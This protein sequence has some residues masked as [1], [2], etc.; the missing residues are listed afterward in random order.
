MI[1]QEKI[2]KA[3][4][5]IVYFNTEIF[6][7]SFTEPIV[8]APHTNRW[9]YDMANN[10]HTAILS[11]RKH[12]KSISVYSYLMW[13]LLRNVDEHRE[14]FYF[15][16]NQDIAS[17]H[18][19]NIKKLIQTNPYF[20]QVTNHTPA[21][22]ILE[23]SWDGKHMFTVKPQGMTSFKRG[24]HPHEV[25]CDDI[26]ADPTNELNLSIIEKINNI[27]FKEVMSL[28]KEGG[29]L[30]LVG[31]AQT[32]SDLFF[33]IKQKS[34]K[35]KWGMYKAVKNWEKKQ[36]LWKELFSFERLMEIR[37][38]EIGEKAFNQEYMCSPVYS[39]KAYF[40]KEQIEIVT[41]PGLGNLESLR[42][43][44]RVLL[45][46]DIGK[47]RHPS[48]I[49]VFE[50]QGDK[51][52]QRLSQWLDGWDYSRQLSLIKS[53]VED[54]S[55]DEGYFDATR[56]EFDTMT[57]QGEM[58]DALKP[59]IFKKKNK[60]AMASLFEKIVNRKNIELIDDHRQTDQILSVNND[61]DAIETNQGHGDSFWSIAMAL[62][63]GEE[64]KVII[65]W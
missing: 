5:D 44:N 55:V 16:Y 60:G 59:L 40:K 6:P 31:T 18:T 36:V 37:D 1:E 4:H 57:E 52:I 24:L 11:A 64:K 46:W 47:K 65:D 15:S 19:S 63:A 54:F 29:H 26:L 27:F 45:G 14:I 3:V 8:K 50:Q 23:Y 35:F 38:E 10:T 43:D 28:P 39:E 56:G 49:V 20:E 30:K 2:A 32:Q 41:N 34:T 7:L 21:A 9:V 62:Y 48:H 58:P 22:G 51:Y 17:Y 33:Q 25:V 61:L 53:I 42:T 12:L 13:R